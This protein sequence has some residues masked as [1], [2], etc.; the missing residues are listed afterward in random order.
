MS[1]FNLILSREK[2]NHQ[3]Y[4]SVKG[5]VKSKLNEY[6]SDKKNSRKINL[7]TVGIYTSIPLFIIG[8]ILLLSSITISFVVIF[9]TGKNE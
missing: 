1:N 9:K 8:A 3:Q 5:I 7:A 2:F 4:A 6:Y